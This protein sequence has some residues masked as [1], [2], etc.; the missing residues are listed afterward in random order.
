[1]AARRSNLNPFTL[2]EAADQSNRR[3][4]CRKAH[5]IERFNYTISVQMRQGNPR[6]GAAASLA[7]WSILHGLTMLA[8]DDFVGPP[9]DVETV[10]DPILG[11]LL[12]GI[13]SVPPAL[14]AN[15]WTAPRL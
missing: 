15:F 8:I 3:L 12:A 14:P 5:R 6:E 1:M 10:V 9:K 7:I 11:A 2:A 13:A 4:R